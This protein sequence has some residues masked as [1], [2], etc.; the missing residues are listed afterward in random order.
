MAASTVTR[1][2]QVLF[3]SSIA[4]EMLCKLEVRDHVHKSDPLLRKHTVILS[5]APYRFTPLVIC[6][7][8]LDHLG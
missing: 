4:T 2:L 3:E 8:F 7:H 1:H 6:L 5:Y